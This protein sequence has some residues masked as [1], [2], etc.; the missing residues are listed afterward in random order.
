MKK[1]E[2]GKEKKK[3]RE[4]GR[5]AARDKEG[6]RK[7]PRKEEDSHREPPRVAA[8]HRRHRHHRFNL[9]SH[10]NPFFVKFSILTS[11]IVFESFFKCFYG[12]VFEVQK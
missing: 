1:K 3:K 10:R 7:Q 12:F 4:E 2:K 11:K 6:E 5:P 8:R 9:V